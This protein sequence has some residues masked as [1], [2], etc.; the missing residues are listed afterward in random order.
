MSSAPDVTTPAHETAVIVPVHRAADVALEC[1]QSL[2]QSCVITPADVIVVDDCSGDDTP[3]RL[4]THFPEFRHVRRDVNGGFAV[5]ANTGLR[6]APADAAYIALVNSDA[7]V[8]PDWLVPALAALRADAG[9]G[10]VAPRIMHVGR[11]A[12]IESAGLAYTIAGWGRRRGLG[13]TFG[14]PYD[15]PAEVLGPT[16]CAAI[17]RR[18]ALCDVNALFRDDFV[19]YYE[20]V[21]LALRLR[22]RGWRCRYEPA[23]VVHHRVSVSYARR[24][25]E[26]MLRISGNLE[27]VFW[28]HMPGRLMPLALLH[29]LAFD[30]LHAGRSLLDGHPIAFLRGK[31]GALVDLPSVWKER[32]RSAPPADLEPWIERHWLGPVLRSRS[33]ASIPAAEQ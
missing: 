5:A 33:P 4:Q 22:A 31:C 20:D 27:R 32:R 17:Y 23:S 25:A 13:R 2:R 19:C 3:D 30:V 11:P 29:H 1:L 16:G 18:A 28:R 21:E 24:P 12:L 10:S 6:A 14:P 8:D 7:V 15:S 9:L 26:R